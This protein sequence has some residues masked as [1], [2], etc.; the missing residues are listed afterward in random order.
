MPPADN[1][2]TLLFS[3]TF[4]DNVRR[5]ASNFMRRQ[6]VRVEVGMQQAPAQ[7]E[8]RFL[9]VPQGSKLSALL[10]VIRDVDGQTVVF[11]ARKVDVDGIED[12]LYDEGVAVVG[13]HG[14]RDM[15]TRQNA[16][17]WF[18]TGRAKIMVA[19]DVAARGL[20]LPDVAHV[21]NMDLPG[22]VDTYTHRVGRTGR[23]GRP[24]LATSFWNENDVAFLGALVRQLTASR[25]PVPAG[26]EQFEGER[27]FAQ[28]YRRS[29]WVR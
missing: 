28:G 2:Q 9:R 1:R 24:G 12:Y 13:I 18:A 4:A 25:A 15:K 20:D 26:L 11:A 3:A 17:R 21:V 7:I 23:A 27:R 6:Q 16:L 10:D 5:L 19:T 29:T 8:Q 14:D 22:D